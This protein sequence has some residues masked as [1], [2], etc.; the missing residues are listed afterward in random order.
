MSYDS[1]MPSSHALPMHISKQKPIGMPT[2]VV[3]PIKSASRNTLE[4][5]KAR[6][7]SLLF[8]N[9]TKEQHWQQTAPGE[10]SFLAISGMD[11]SHLCIF[12]LQNNLLK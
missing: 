7:N 3:H 4:F 5:N 12:Y 10:R 2:E 11:V 8:T 6:I 1:R 9:S